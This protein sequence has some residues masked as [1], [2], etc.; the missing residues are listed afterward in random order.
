MD[1]KVLKH[2]IR[3]SCQ[4]K[5]FVVSRD[6]HE[7]HLRA[8][9]NFGHTIG[10]ALERAG[11]YG[12][13][14]HG[15]AILYGMIGESFIAQETGMFGIRDQ[16]RMEQLIQRIPI[17]SLTSMKL[18]NAALIE[19]MKMDKKT[20]DGAIRMSLPYSIGKVSLP[21]GVSIQSVNRA[22]DYLKEYGQ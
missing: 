11:H 13:L 6:E 2:L 12:R 20:K 21:K 19:T 5:A 18:K 1:Q 17:P 9:L 3:R 22:V 4:I 8:K 15:E 14:K 16:I 10:H 7:Q